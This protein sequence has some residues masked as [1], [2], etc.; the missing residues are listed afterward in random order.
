MALVS[1]L[2]GLLDFTLIKEFTLRFLSAYLGYYYFFKKNS[3]YY[4]RAAMIFGG[5]ICLGDLAYTYAVYGGF[6]VIRAYYMFVPAEFVTYNHNFF[7][8]ICG[9]SFVFLLSDY[10]TR[11]SSGKL[12]LWLIPLMFLGV[13]L[14]TS[15][16]ALVAMIIMTVILIGKALVSQNKGK[17]AYTLITI[18]VV[19]LILSLFVMQIATSVLG[20]SSEFLDTITVRLVDEPL[21]MI[22]KMMGN[23]YSVD[24]METVEWREEASN[25]AY[26]YYMNLPSSDQAIGIGYG[27]FLA[28]DIGHGY[29][30]HNGVLLILIE[31]GAIGTLIYVTMILSFW[32]KVSKFKLSSP[33]LVSIVFIILFVT[34]H[35]KEITTFFAFLIMGSLI[36]EIK[37]ASLAQEEVS[38]EE[39]QQD[40]ALANQ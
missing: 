9:T 2:N 18:T 21:A 23:S 32:A 10:L 4:L 29:D 27:G 5:L 34:S 17:R 11:P 36:G 38:E 6:P 1:L 22:N 7:G 8:Y 12:N 3:Y 28:R 30:A 20:I 37:Y 13:L 40:A 26:N 16:G 31:T 35:N 39:Q 24:S 15:R 14:S 33:A 19:C 25:M